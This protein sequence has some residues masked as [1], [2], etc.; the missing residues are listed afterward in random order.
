[1]AEFPSATEWREIA[2]AV[3][4]QPTGPIGPKTRKERSDAKDNQISHR[5]RAEDEANA[6]A[7]IVFQRGSNHEMPQPVVAAG[8]ARGPLLERSRAR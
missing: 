5:V 1:L 2:N 3:N 8:S 7:R 6:K 4:H